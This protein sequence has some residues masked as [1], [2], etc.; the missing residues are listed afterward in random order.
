MAGSMDAARKRHADAFDGLREHLVDHLGRPAAVA[1]GGQAQRD[2]GRGD[3]AIQ[4]LI[5]AYE[6]AARPRRA[7]RRASPARWTASSCPTTCPRTGVPSVIDLV[8]EW[9][10]DDGPLDGSTL[11]RYDDASAG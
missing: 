5:G 11:A 6:D 7:A 3:R 10:D 2:R 1:A 4:D 9:A 8:N